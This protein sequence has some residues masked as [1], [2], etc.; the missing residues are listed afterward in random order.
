MEYGATLPPSGHNLEHGCK[1]NTKSVRHNSI[2]YLLII[3]VIIITISIQ[4]SV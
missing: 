2:S 1:R 3:I 4:T